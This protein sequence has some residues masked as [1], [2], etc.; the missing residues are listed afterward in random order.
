ML[1]VAATERELALLDGLATFCCGIGP[2]EAALQTSRAL[3]ERRPDFVVHV[4]IAG[5]R[6]FEPPAL[7]IG[8][9][10]VYCD[11]IDPASTLPRVERAWPDAALLERAR[12]A[13]PEAHVLPIATC[14]KVGAGTGFDVEAMEGFG[15]LRACELADV[16]AVELRAISNSPEEADRARWRFDEAFAALSAALDLL[17]VL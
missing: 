17:D 16:P 3:A 10:A 4:G 2:V 5:S 14:G 7:V 8:S 6:T 1:V 12:A 11:V 15:V 13:L 9:E